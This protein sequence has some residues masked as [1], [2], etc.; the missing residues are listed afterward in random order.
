ME[1]KIGVGYGAN[2]NQAREALV[3]AAAGVENV[4]KDPAP[5][6]GVTNLQ[7]SA[8]EMTLQAWTSSGDYWQA[9]ADVFQAAKEALDAAGIEI[10]FPHQVAV[11]YGHEVEAPADRKGN[12]AARPRSAGTYETSADHIQ[13]PSEG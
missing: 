7:D 5:W 9:R 6:A 11:P 10:P 13:D 12:G 4:L 1:L 8:V 2:L 3:A